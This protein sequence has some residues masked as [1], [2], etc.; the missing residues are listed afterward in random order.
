MSPL[1][2]NSLHEN[3]EKKNSLIT[4]PNLTAETSN[5]E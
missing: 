5:L 3:Y 1:K 4:K 2:K